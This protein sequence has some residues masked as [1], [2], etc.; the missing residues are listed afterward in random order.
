MLRWPGTKLWCAWRAEAVPCSSSSVDC[1]KP[2]TSLNIE[3]ERPLVLCC[4]GVPMA[5]WT[6]LTKGEASAG[7]SVTVWGGIDEVGQKG[8]GLY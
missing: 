4:G 5:G 6:V 7:P 8:C 3:D 2:D 1:V